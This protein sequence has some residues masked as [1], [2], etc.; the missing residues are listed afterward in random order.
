M[1]S[2]LSFSLGSKGEQSSSA[3]EDFDLE[4]TNTVLIANKNVDGSLCYS[5]PQS[6]QKDA[7]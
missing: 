2:F 3:K 1:K 4:E 6:T 7:R 5:S